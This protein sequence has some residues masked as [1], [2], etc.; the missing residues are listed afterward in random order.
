[1]QWRDDLS[2]KE[3][4][5][6]LSEL[7]GHP[8]QSALW[9]DAK[10]V[11]YGISDQRLALYFQNKLAALIRVENRGLKAFLK[12]AWIPQGPTQAA[13]IKFKRIENTILSRLKQS[14]YMLCVSSPWQAASALEKQGFR[15]TVWIDLSLGK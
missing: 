11:V 8:L 12:L 10:K 1:M 9:G 2:S 14:G 6:L 4:N 7:G 13:D 3:W 15:K 5:V